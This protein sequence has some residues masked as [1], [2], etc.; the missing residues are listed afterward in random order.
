MRYVLGMTL[1]VTIVLFG[2]LCL[3]ASMTAE[4][5]GIGIGIFIIAVGALIIQRI[6]PK[7]KQW[8][9]ET[10]ARIKSSESPQ[11]KARLAEITTQMNTIVR[12]SIVGTDS[13]IET[14]SAATR[15]IAGDLIAGPTGSAIGIL[16]AKKQGFTKF[17]VEYASGRKEIETVKDNS[18]RFQQLTRY[19][20]N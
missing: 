10:S 12:T 3:I 18:P 5:Q 11:A 7:W 17:L 16:T 8:Y 13:K 9:D 20:N 1:G 15:A 19:L 4:G 6:K 14:G 2:L